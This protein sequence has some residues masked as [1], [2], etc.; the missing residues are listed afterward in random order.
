MVLVFLFNV[1]LLTGRAPR[2][3]YSVFYHRPAFFSSICGVNSKHLANIHKFN[4]GPRRKNAPSVPRKVPSRRP[5]IS[6]PRR[7]LFIPFRPPAKGRGKRIFPASV[8]NF[9]PFPPF[10][11]ENRRTRPDSGRILPENRLVR[12]SRPATTFP[13]RVTRT[14]RTAPSPGRRRAAFSGHFPLRPLSSVGTVSFFANA[15]LRSSDPFQKF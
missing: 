15:S 5:H 7:R 12:T 6:C 8:R 3:R 1:S 14:A 9:P 10:S 11:A 4:T 13:A 2:A